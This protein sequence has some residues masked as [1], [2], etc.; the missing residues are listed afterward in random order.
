MNSVF[1]HMIADG[2]DDESDYGDECLLPLNDADAM[3]VNTDHLGDMISSNQEQKDFLKDSIAGE[4]MH[5]DTG[6][7]PDAG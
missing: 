7:C 6:L 5:L 3:L 4:R 1:Q 2:S